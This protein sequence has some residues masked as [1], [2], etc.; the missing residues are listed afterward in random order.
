MNTASYEC[1]RNAVIAAHPLL[2]YCHRIGLEM[3]RAGGEWKC[4]CPLLLSPDRRD[5]PVTLS[6][7][8][9]VIAPCFCEPM[10]N[11]DLPVS[12]AVLDQTAASVLGIGSFQMGQIFKAHPRSAQDKEGVPEHGRENFWLLLRLQRDHRFFQQSVEL[13]KDIGWK[14]PWLCR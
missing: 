13:F 5:R 7:R 2:E 4:L 1:D 11:R 6:S 12:L 9:T 10:I 14:W 3:R 8:N